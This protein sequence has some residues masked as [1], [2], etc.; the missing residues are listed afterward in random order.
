[1]SLR[2]GVEWQGGHHWP[3]CFRTS[4]S[5]RSLLCAFWMCLAF[6]LLASFAAQTCVTPGLGLPEFNGRFSGGP[7]CWASHWCG[8]SPSG[9]KLDGVLAQTWS[10]RWAIRRHS[11]AGGLR[12]HPGGLWGCRKL[13]TGWAEKLPGRGKPPRGACTGSRQW[14]RKGNP[15][16]GEKGAAGG[17]AHPEAPTLAVLSPHLTWAPLEVLR[18]PALARRRAFP[19]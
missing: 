10:G 2:E 7:Q 16:P 12:R 3:C 4:R 5:A 9:E 6:F 13:R 8:L 11:G 19:A 15:A 17:A 18:T 1:M 14:Q